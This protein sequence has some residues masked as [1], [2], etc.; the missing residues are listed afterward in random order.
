[1]RRSYTPPSS[2]EQAISD[3]VTELYI[4]VRDHAHG[5]TEA[6]EEAKAIC[7]KILARLG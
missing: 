2:D 1:M 7:R 3:L 5:D 6:K 4:K